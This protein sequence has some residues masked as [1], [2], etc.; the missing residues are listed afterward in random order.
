MVSPR[1]PLIIRSY[2]KINL[3]LRVINK[4]KDNYH[5]LETLFA[6]IDLSDEIIIKP[7]K[8]SLVKV[9]CSDPLVPRDKANLCYRAVRLLREERGLNYY[10]LDII[11]KKRIPTGAGL[12]GGSSNAAAVLSGLNKSW[13]LKIPR[14][15][16]AE[17]AA[18]IGSDVPFFIYEKKFAQG[19][20][21]GDK[22]KPIPVLSGIKLYCVLIVAKIHVSTPLIFKEWDSFSQLTTPKHNVKILSS[23]L[24][25]KGAKIAPGL[26]FNNLEPVTT[27]LYPK[28]RQVRNALKRQGLRIVSM[29]GS[30]PA[31]FGIC[32]S[33][34]EAAVLSKKIQ[35]KHK[36]WRVFNVCTV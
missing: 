23:E 18:K 34:K 16:L 35:R 4:R 28:V 31:V 36:N 5:N 10:G 17:L 27:S 29:S 33:G 25:S 22:I 7:R 20:G 9:R 13:K 21:R 1:A 14:L 2:A 26:I 6:R 12:G 24:R 32:S 11:I 15:K 30:G 19:L 8:D 3:Y